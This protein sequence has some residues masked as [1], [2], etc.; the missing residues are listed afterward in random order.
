MT[1][2]SSAGHKVPQNDRIAALD[3]LRVVSIL[4][5]VAIHVFGLVY[6]NDE[7]RG[8]LGWKLAAII[9]I[10]SVWTVPG[11]IMLSGYLN[12]RDKPHQLG[13]VAFYRH[14][15]PGILIPMIFW[16]LFYIIIVRFLLNDAT[17]RPL[18]ILQNLF[19][20]KVYTALYFFWIILGLYLVSPI[21]HSYIS[22]GARNRSLILGTSIATWTMAIF[23]SFGISDLLGY[24]RRFDRGA[25]TMW[26]VFVG[27]FVLGHALGSIRLRRT[28]FV[29]VV[30]AAAFLLGELVWQNTRAHS[31]VLIPVLNPGNALGVVCLVATC[32]IFIAFINSTWLINRL[33]LDKALA[34][35]SE[36]AFGV[37][38]LH[39]FFLA[40]VVKWFGLER[41]SHFSFAMA[42][43]ILI[44]VTSFVAT[45]LIRRIPGL[46]RIV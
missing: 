3:A 12:L 11:F 24:S 45:A 21:L 37:F 17:I 28:Q 18:G 46:K 43:Y 27:Y 6:I 26:V 31:S 41:V 2:T 40:I 44:V 22:A 5:V 30:I 20:G 36:L 35:L 14:R 23:V 25:L 4:G 32:L 33:H 29:F 8:S 10:G 15:L 19:D 13:T 9:N 34:V 38:C 16:H 1:T 42:T 39:L 7:I